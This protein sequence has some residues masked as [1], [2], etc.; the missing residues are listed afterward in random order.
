MRVTKQQYKQWQFVLQVCRLLFINLL[1]LNLFPT[2][3]CTWPTCNFTSI[4]YVKLDIDQK[5]LSFELITGQWISDSQLWFLNWWQICDACKKLIIKKLRLHNYCLTQF[6]S[7]LLKSQHSWLV[8]VETNMKCAER[9][10][11]TKGYIGPVTKMK[12]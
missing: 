5:C 1:T 3:D 11:A 10:K 8:T 4:Y 2:V 6:R 9:A 12:N 7:H